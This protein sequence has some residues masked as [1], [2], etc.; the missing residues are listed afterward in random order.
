MIFQ[1]LSQE[2]GRMIQVAQGSTVC[3][4]EMGVLAEGRNRI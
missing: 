4:L 2:L 1:T 3:E